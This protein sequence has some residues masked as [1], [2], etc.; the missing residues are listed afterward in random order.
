MSTQ[1]SRGADGQDAVLRARLADADPAVRA[2]APTITSDSVAAVAREVTG[3]P[4][5]VGDADRPRS[6]TRR[7]WTYAAAAAVLVASGATMAATWHR[8]PAATD[9]APATTTPSASALTLHLPAATPARCPQVTAAT[10]GDAATLAVTAVVTSVDSGRATLT[11]ERWQRGGHGEATVVIDAPSADLVA[12][13]GAVEL[14]PG[15][16]ILLAA[17]DDSLLA[18]GMSAPWTPELAATYSAA[19]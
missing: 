9:A 1:E 15:T 18:C 17:S 5:A 7:R 16:R 2:G 4:T 10:L 12:L 3:I 14:T 13:I 19:F 6:A 8:G 11:V